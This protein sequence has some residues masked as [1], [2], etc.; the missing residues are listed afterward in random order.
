M[1]VHSS[2]VQCVSDTCIH[3]H[4]GQITHCTITITITITIDIVTVTVHLFLKFLPSV[5]L[6]F[7][8]F[9]VLQLIIFFYLHSIFPYGANTSLLALGC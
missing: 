1:Y 9:V 6:F 3:M 4:R 2:T 7:I 8:L 5:I